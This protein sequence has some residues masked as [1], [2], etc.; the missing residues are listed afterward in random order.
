MRLGRVQFTIGNIVDLDDKEMVEKAREDIIETLVQ[1]IF[2]E[3]EGA[4]RNEMS[5]TED[6]TLRAA[7][8]PSFLQP[9]QEE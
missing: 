7:D 1:K 4:I 2:H 3:G 9:E 6:P 5:E 8:I